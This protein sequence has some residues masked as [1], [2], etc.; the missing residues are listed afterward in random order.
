[1]RLRS[2]TINALPGIDSRFTFEPPDAG[3]T[4]VTG[5]NG[6][7]KSSLARALRHLLA[8]A[9]NDP[10]ALSLEA[11]FDSGD[12]RWQVRR[13]GSQILWLRNGE[14]DT[15]PSLPSGGQMNLY[16]LSMESLLSDDDDD[17]QLAKRI[18]RD[19]RGGFDLDALRDTLPARFGRNEATLWSK[20]D[21]ALHQVESAHKHLQSEEAKLPELEQDIESAKAAADRAAHLRRALELHTAIEQRI[22]RQEEFGGF[23]DGMDK[24]KGDEL[25][26]LDRLE[27]NVSTLDTELQQK[28]RELDSDKDALEDTGLSGGLPESEAVERIGRLLRRL[29]DKAGDRQRTQERLRDAKAGLEDVLKLFKGHGGAPDL[30]VESI[31]PAEKLVEDLVNARDRRRLHQLRLDLAGKPPDDADI[32]QLRHGVDALRAWLA[33]NTLSN[34]AALNAPS[35]AKRLRYF[36]LAFAAAAALAAFIEQAYWSLAGALLAGAAML[37]SIFPGRRSPATPSNADQ[38]R[39]RYE[40]TGLDPLEA[41]SPDAVREHLTRHIEPRLNQLVRKRDLAQEAPELH[42]QVKQED[43]EIERLEA[44]KAELAQ[45]IGIDPELTAAPFHRFV[46]LTGQWDAARRSHEE[47]EAKINELDRE[48]AADATK[49]REFLDQ[50]RNADATTLDETNGDSAI[51]ELRI[52]VESLSTRLEQAKQ[53]RGDIRSHSREIASLKSRIRERQEERESLFAEVGLAPD[54]RVELENRIGQLEDWKTAQDALKA[55]NRDEERLR[56]ELAEQQDL[57]AAVDEGMVE[58]LREDLEQEQRRANRQTE[59]IEERQDIRTRLEEAERRHDLEEATSNLDQARAALEDKRDRALRQQATDVLLEEVETQFKSDQEPALLRRAREIFKQ[60]TADAFSLELGDGNRFAARD[61]IQ[62]QPRSLE[63]LSSGTRM[64]LLLALR[65]AWTEA[66]ERGGESLPLFLDEALTTSDE[67][68]FTEMANTLMRLNEASERQIFY[69]SARRHEGALWR[70]ATGTEP[71]MVDLGEVR[72]K[73]S[74]QPA[75]V[76]ELDPSPRIPPPDDVDAAQYAA[77]IEVPLLDPYSEPG[78]IHLFH[79]LRDDLKLLHRLM[80]TWR[81]TTLGQFESLLASNAAKGAIPDAAV[82]GRFAQRCAAIRAWTELWRQGR[83]QP[84]NRAV[85][86]QSRAVSETFIDR[87]AEL[88]DELQGDGTALINALRQHRLPGFRT[89]K[90][91]ELEQWLANEGY[92]DEQA[93]LSAEERC[94]LTL[95]VVTPSS[96]EE[97]A[98]VNQLLAWLEGTQYPES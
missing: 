39:Q 77:L 25:D 9:R 14:A 46:D 27:Q 52:S 37:W 97:A 72:R 20:A 8:P 24:L 53:A 57:I 31:E 10:L 69:L 17:K 7:G 95:A 91:S 3:V 93:Q 71:A 44:Q 62:G 19:L 45:S 56:G 6:I 68:R 33:A 30:S 23:V 15:A 4:L 11:E 18:G 88:A 2:L 21:K 29:E 55:A 38:A 40:E 51:A 35:R 89:T 94:R 66:Q 98:D 1:M 59:L 34:D 58:R 49:V 60:V 96:D 42:L 13:N 76:F 87:A 90:A 48:I 5:P 83:G 36:G 85:L 92:I 64:Q 78:G 82:R 47:L 80:A 79:L 81:V 63:E 50:W 28:R 32:E 54:Q 61:L 43:A 12:S 22:V 26:R 73:A 67:D 41:W 75:E 86:E 84:V 70:Q 65:L 16:R 74:S